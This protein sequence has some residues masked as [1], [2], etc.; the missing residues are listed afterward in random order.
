MPAVCRVLYPCGSV[1]CLLCA[2]YYTPGLGGG[3]VSDA[4]CVQ[5]I[6]PLGWEGGGCLMPTVCRVLYPWVG[7]GGVS[8]AYCVQG[9]I[10]LGGYQMPTVCRVLYPWGSD[11]C[12]L[13]TRY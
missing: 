2:G 5:G 3:G 4:Y 11:R 1:R 6:I 10:P 13:C 8:D 9:I 7:G 12:L